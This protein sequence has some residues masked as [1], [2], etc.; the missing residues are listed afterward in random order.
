MITKA[1]ASE[2]IVGDRQMHDRLVA[3][4][5]QR[6]QTLGRAAGQRHGRLAARQ[7]DHAHI[8]PEHP[9]DMPLPKALAQASLAAKRFA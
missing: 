3:G 9:S 4:R 5:Q 6:L 2:E 8:A 7:I 1:C